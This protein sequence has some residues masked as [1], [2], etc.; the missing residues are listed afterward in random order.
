MT[1]T[2]IV[3]IA[4]SSAWQRFVYSYEYYTDSAPIAL[5]L[6]SDQPLQWHGCKTL[7][8]VQ[9]EY[10]HPRIHIFIQVFF[11]YHRHALGDR[12]CDC[13]LCRSSH[14]YKVDRIME[15]VNAVTS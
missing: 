15:S 10:M 2:Y 1:P 3:R 4:Y 12:T 9:T 6:P 8:Q 11:N 7:S 14:D 5:L 13:D